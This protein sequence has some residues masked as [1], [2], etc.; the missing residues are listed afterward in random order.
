MIVSFD[1]DNTLDQKWIQDIAKIFIN[2]DCEVHITTSRVSGRNVDLETV[3]K[4]LGI[5]R[6]NYTEGAYKSETLKVI[7]ADIHFDDMEDE[8]DKINKETDCNALLVGFD[9]AFTKY[10]FSNE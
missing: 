9:I 6:I 1:F 10:L 7:G 5:T 3:A 4:E 8:V 2:A